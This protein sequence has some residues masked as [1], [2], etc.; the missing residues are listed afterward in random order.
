MSEKL[1]DVLTDRLLQL[2]V[3][4]LEELRRRGVTRS[5]NNPVGDYT[6]YLV[7]RRLGLTLLANSKTGHDATDTQGVRYQIKGR[8]LTPENPSTQLSAIRDLALKQ[9]DVLIAVVYRPDF[10]V[11]YA[12]KLPHAVVEETAS[13]VERTNSHRL[14]MPKSVLADRRVVDITEIL[15]TPQALT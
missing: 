1:S 10:T 2:H 3:E 13:F 14:M 15:R 6:E 5:A 8:R 12:A 9:F 11:D 4:I 7:A